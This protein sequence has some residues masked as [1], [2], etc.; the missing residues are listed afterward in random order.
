[1]PGKKFGAENLPDTVTIKDR[2]FRI[3]ACIDVAAQTIVDPY[4]PPPPDDELIDCFC[5]VRREG[6]MNAEDMQPRSRRA[7]LSG[8][9]A[10]EVRQRCPGTGN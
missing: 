10:D 9:S 2:G 3:A 4:T 5:G 6:T 8:A 1:M 7:A